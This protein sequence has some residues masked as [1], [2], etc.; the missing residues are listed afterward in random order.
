MASTG[1]YPSLA[2]IAGPFDAILLD[3]YGVFWQGNATGFFPGA[4]KVMEALVASGKI[5]GILSNSTQLS[6]REGDKLSRHGISLG[7]HFHFLVTSG[8]VARNVFLNGP[9]PFQTPNK[10]FWVLGGIHPR[11]HSHQD[12]FA[13]TGYQETSDIGQADFIYVGIPH[14]QGQD[15]TDPEIFR[16]QILALDLKL[17]MMCINPDRFAH[18]GQ[19]PRAVVRQGSIAAMYQEMGGPV[20]YIGKPYENAFAYAMQ[21]FQVHGISNP[22][23]V[24]MVGDTPECDIKGA[25]KF[26]MKSALITETG[27]MG[28]RVLHFGREKA[29]RQL[30]VDEVPHYFIERFSDD[31]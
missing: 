7:Q 18:E 6:S 14:V 28:E 12:I 23:D 24:L 13:A 19:P 15:Q 8:E 16:R 26:G 30:C 31:I 10:K 25:R 21:N 22:H 5:V 1:G 2:H 17:P 3:A 20:Y 9:L 29:I 27:I 4:P 11:F